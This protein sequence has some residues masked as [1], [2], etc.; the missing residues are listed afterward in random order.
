MEYIS[1]LVNWWN[2]KNATRKD[3]QM[4]TC[5]LWG[6]QCK[7]QAFKENHCSQVLQKQ[8]NHLAQLTAQ[9]PDQTPFQTVPRV[10][11]QAQWKERRSCFP[12]CVPHTGAGHVDKSEKVSVFLCILWEF[13]QHCLN[14]YFFSLDRTNDQNNS[15]NK[16]QKET[17]CNYWNI[18]FNTFFSLIEINSEKAKC[19]ILTVLT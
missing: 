19:I 4:T 5:S 9:A 2:I 17:H 7:L 10:F 6:N 14:F 11:L 12:A 8:K 15:W 3:P 18:W 1:K 16:N 13:M